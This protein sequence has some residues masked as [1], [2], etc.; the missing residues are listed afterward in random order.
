LIAIDDFGNDLHPYAIR[1]IVEAIQDWSETRDLTV[2][3]ASHSPVLL[4]E[5]KE[6]PDSVFVMQSELLERPV[7]L[8]ELYD[9]DWLARFSLGRL[10]EHGEF[11]GQRPVPV[12]VTATE[13][14]NAI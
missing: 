4:N 5:F 12:D 9:P 11:G 8:T 2:C 7:P 14:D 6:R 3:L 13:G 1:A 10:Y